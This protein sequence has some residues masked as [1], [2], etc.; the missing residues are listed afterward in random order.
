MTIGLNSA[1]YAQVGEKVIDFRHVAGFES[2]RMTQR[3][4]R[5]VDEVHVLFR[6]EPNATSQ[7]AHEKLPVAAHVQNHGEEGERAPDVTELN[8]RKWGVEIGK[9]SDAETIKCVCVCVCVRVCV[10]V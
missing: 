10:G 7:L 6:I 4:V 1:P 5:Q 3:V 2:D 9:G 8:G